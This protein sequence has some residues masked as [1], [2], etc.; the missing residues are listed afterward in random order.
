MK[1]I[2]EL[3]II[4]NKILGNKGAWGIVSGEFKGQRKFHLGDNIKYK[5][6]TVKEKITF[7]KM[8]KDSLKKY[9]LIFQRDYET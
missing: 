6:A 7:L 2:S 5:E 8:F 9:L 4:L 1:I 3:F